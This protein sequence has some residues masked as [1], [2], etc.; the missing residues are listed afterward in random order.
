MAALRR[1]V[2]PEELSRATGIDP[3]FTRAFNRIAQMESRLIRETLTPELLW[4]A[5]RLGFGDEKIA[6]LADRTADQIRK[7]RIDWDIRPGL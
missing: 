5:K 6:I 1:D 4:T 3:W 7:T 2:S